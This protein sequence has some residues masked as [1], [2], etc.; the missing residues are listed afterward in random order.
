[1]RENR[2]ELEQLNHAEVSMRRRL[3]NSAH[4][5]LAVYRDGVRN[6]AVWGAASPVAVNWLAG[7]YVVNTAVGGIFVNAGDYSS[8][9]YR[10][11]YAQRLGS[12]LETLLAYQSGDSLYV[13]S[14]ADSIPEGDLRSLKPI[15]SEAFA[16]R[17]AARIP[18]SHTQIISSYE[19]VERGR[20][21]TVDPV[22]QADMQLQPFLDLQFR[23]P[24]P[25][26]AF[27]PADIEAVRTSGTC[28]PEAA[29]R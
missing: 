20:V 29:P 28:S 26:L 9:G 21:T 22:G 6:A 23:Q 15:R 27:L 7:N 8:Y 4:V 10:V 16:A 11:A 5:E 24:L 3:N 17:I 2:P 25:S 18:T 13:Q 1:M 19:W 12:H 14:T